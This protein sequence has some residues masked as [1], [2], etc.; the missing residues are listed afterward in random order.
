M[1][2]RPASPIIAQVPSAARSL[3]D[4]AVR[5]W[6]NLPSDNRCCGARTL[7]CC[8][9]SAAISTISNSPISSMPPSCAHRMPMPTSAASTPARRDKCPASTP[10]SPARIMPRTRSARCPRWRRTRNATAVR[11]ICRRGRRSPSIASCMW[12]IRS[13]WWSPTRSIAPV[14]RPKPSRSIT[15]RDRPWCPRAQLSSQ[16]HRSSTATART[17]RPI[18]TRP[19][20]R[21]RPM[22]RLRP[23]RMWSSSASSSTGSPPIRSSRA[24]SPASM[25]QAP[26]ATRCIAAFSGPGCS[27]TTSPAPR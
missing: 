16:A 23:R 17:T 21:P 19:A 27:A 2:S 24:A 11:C 22:R 7:A 12:V 26:G 1:L 15:R 25:T 4:G 10:C 13:R 8:A 18:S 6:A 5:S 3:A 9:G 20:T 14:M